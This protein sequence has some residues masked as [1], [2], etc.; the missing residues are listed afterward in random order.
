MSEEKKTEKKIGLAD[1][2]GESGIDVSAVGLSKSGVKNS[3]AFGVKEPMSDV[4][5]ASARSEGVKTAWAVADKKFR[6]GLSKKAQEE[7]KQ[8]KVIVVDWK[9]A[10]RACNAEITKMQKNLGGKPK[11][12]DAEIA[13]QY[14]VYRTNEKGQFVVCQKL[15][16]GRRPQMIG[17]VERLAKRLD[18]DGIDFIDAG[19][20]KLGPVL[21]IEA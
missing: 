12:I 6:S 9:L 16:Q 18:A 7:L 20:D 14:G 1:M 13:G 4:L 5:I 21:V 11:V 2:L 19:N 8:M 10:R 3:V 17:V 15:T